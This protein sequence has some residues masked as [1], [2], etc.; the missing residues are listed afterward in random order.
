MADLRDPRSCDRYPGQ[1]LLNGLP[2]VALAFA[3]SP[4]KPFECV[5]DGPTVESV[6]R[7]GVAYEPVVVVVTSQSGVEPSKEV[8][9]LRVPVRLNP[10]LAPLAGG[11]QLLSRRAT[12]DSW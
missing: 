7:V 3:A 5:D 4:V 6:Q 9:P 1:D 10:F 2:G 12:L 8:L 11:P